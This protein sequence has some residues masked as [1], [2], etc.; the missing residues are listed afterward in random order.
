MFENKQRGMEEVIFNKITEKLVYPTRR[1]K[2][3]SDDQ[4]KFQELKNTFQM[5]F[6]YAL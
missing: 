5:F 1:Y 4:F 6:L 2:N 3:L